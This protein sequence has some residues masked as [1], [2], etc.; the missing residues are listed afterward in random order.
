VRLD[1]YLVENKWAESKSKAQALIKA[2]CVSVIKDS[3]EKVIRKPAFEIKDNFEGVVQVQPLPE[4]EYVSRA[5][6]KLEQALIKTRLDVKGLRALDMGQ[7]TGGFTEA[8][9]RQG[10]D[11]VTGLDVGHDQ[12]HPKVKAM[13]Q[14]TA[15]EGI[16]GRI[17]EDL[18]KAL[19]EPL[20]DHDLLVMDVSFI[21]QMQV[22]PNLM[23]YLKPG[24][25]LLSLVK[26]QFELGR[27]CLNKNGVVKDQNL[28]D[29]VEQSMRQFYE[30]EGIQVLSYFESAIVGGDGN[31]EFFI[32]GTKGQ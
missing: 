6:Y 15:Y 24:S 27:E 29:N 13:P 16:N 32:Y 30:Q 18:V 1:Q 20:A 25:H 26:P 4:H 7:S 5:G 10:V 28:Y 17:A 2:G 19:G 3:E 31:R 22:L 8:L 9:V 11:F 23:P 14:V 21:S 12:I